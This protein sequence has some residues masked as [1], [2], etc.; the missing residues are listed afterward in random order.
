MI[1]PTKD[2]LIPWL[3]QSKLW[4][5]VLR[6][7]SKEKLLTELDEFS[8]DERAFIFTFKGS[9][10]DQDIIRDHIEEFIDKTISEIKTL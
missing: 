3:I 5:E 1:I 4:I 6:L 8:S 7:K 10:S 9:I 2:P